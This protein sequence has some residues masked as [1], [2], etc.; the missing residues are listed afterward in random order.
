MLPLNR[1]E[2]IAGT[3]ASGLAPAAASAYKCLTP[4]Q[5]DLAYNNVAAVGADYAK[6]KAEEWAASSKVLRQK[7]SQHLDIA[8]GPKERNKWDLYP[9]SDTNAPCMIHIGDYWPRGSKEQF[10]CVAEGAL[11]R[12]AGSEYH[13]PFA[14]DQ[15]ARGDLVIYSP[16]FLCAGILSGK[17]PKP[18]IIPTISSVA[19]SGSS[20]DVCPIRPVVKAWSA[21]IAGFPRKSS[22]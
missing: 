14:L 7:R 5:R 21:T 19:R 9:A 4:E 6:K 1:R 20:K 11:V 17:Q 16:V 18:S 2:I 22:G 10:A 12:G 15:I 3:A 13:Q 8:Y